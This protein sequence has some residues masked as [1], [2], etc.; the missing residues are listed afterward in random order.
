M[1]SLQ[2]QEVSVLSLQ[3]VLKIQVF[4]HFGSK[5]GQVLVGTGGAPPDEAG[6]P[7]A[8]DPDAAGPL[9]TGEGGCTEKDGG[10]GKDGISDG[11]GA[12]YDGDFDGWL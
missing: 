2:K 12:W 7:G 3:F 10:G 5:S 8:G 4:R 1:S 11:A 6:I 9:S